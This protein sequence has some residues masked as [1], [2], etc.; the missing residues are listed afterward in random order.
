MNRSHKHVLSIVHIDKCK[1]NLKGVETMFCKKKQEQECCCVKAMADQLRKFIDQPIIL[2]EEGNKVLV[3]AILRE[4]INDS[5]I[6]VTDVTKE[7][8]TPS[9][10]TRPFGFGT[11]TYISICSITQFSTGN[12]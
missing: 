12:P 9:S 2:F 7:V 5:I 1:E 4:V 8:F 11:D 3:S 6:R 10:G